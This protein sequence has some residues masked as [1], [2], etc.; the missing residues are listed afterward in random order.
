MKYKYIQFIKNQLYIFQV[1]HS[2]RELVLQ[3]ILDKHFI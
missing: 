1:I 2:Y 3:N